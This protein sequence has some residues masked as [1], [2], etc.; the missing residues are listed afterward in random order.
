MRQR[1][2]A[3][4]L[5][6]ALLISTI[7]LIPAGEARAAADKKICIVLDPGHGGTDAGATGTITKTASGS[8]VEV[9]V[10]EKDL[11]LKVAEYTKEILEKDGRFEVYQGDG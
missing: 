2:I 7:G 11:A 6:A 8:A 4:L 1:K 9:K 3:W 5:I 10:K